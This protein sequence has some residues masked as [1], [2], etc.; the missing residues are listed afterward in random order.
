MIPDLIDLGIDILNPVQVR[1]RDMDPARLKR[2]FGKHLCFW[3]AIDTQQVLP[4]G[5]PHD[6]EKEVSKRL[7]EL[8]AGGG[9]VL[10]SVHNIEA[11]VSGEN[12][13]TMFQA[14]QKWGRYPLRHGS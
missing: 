3:G 9:Y 6:V 4:H 11:N 5:T 14:A 13:W 7:E 2:E 12:V 1:A 8:G 10:A